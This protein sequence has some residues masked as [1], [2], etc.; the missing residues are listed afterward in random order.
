MSLHEKLLHPITS[1]SR[2]RSLYRASLDQK[3]PIASHAGAEAQRVEDR[4]RLCRR[5]A[6]SR[7][8]LVEQAETHVVV[9]LF[10]LCSCNACQYR[11]REGKGDGRCRKAD[12][13]P[14]PLPWSP[15]PRRRLPHPHRLLPEQR[16]RLRRTRRSRAGPSRPC[17]RV[18]IVRQSARF[19]RPRA[20]AQAALDCRT[21]ANS[22]AQIGSTSVMFAALRMVVILSACSA[23]PLVSHCPGPMHGILW[24]RTVI[25]TPSSARISAAYDVASSEVVI[26]IV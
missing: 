21:F 24:L 16:Q 23:I 4:K 15:L 26:L 12:L 20:R 9:R 14:S 22:D 18:P 1:M 7:I 3:E 5:D 13:L 8:A 10:L 17:P 6:E 19:P 11:V 25:A 2:R